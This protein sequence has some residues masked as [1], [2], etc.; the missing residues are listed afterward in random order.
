[1]AAQARQH[2]LLLLLHGLQ[3][4]LLILGCGKPRRYCRHGAFNPA[5]HLLPVVLFHL[6]HR[7][8]LQYRASRIRIVAKPSRAL[9][10]PNSASRLLQSHTFQEISLLHRW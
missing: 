9:R 7:N 3:Q 5:N 10:A 8:P 1:M 6:P 2:L 4:V